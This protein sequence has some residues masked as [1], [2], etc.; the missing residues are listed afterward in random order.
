M[1]HH[2]VAGR[3]A[4]LRRFD[5]RDEP[6]G[7]RSDCHGDDGASRRDRQVPESAAALTDGYRAR[8]EER[9]QPALLVMGQA[10]RG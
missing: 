10:A 9:A 7:Q 2:E 6:E 4:T 5:G 8:P 1:A 3:A